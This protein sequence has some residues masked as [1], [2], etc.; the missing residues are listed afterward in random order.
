ME[1]RLKYNLDFIHNNTIQSFLFKTL[2]KEF[3]TASKLTSGL[4]LLKSRINTYQNI[5]FSIDN[6]T[7]LT[8][9]NQNNYKVVYWVK[10]Q[11]W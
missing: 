2:R 5:I 4:E 6:K 8:Y 9:S 10:K 7:A 1:L 11:D 3:I